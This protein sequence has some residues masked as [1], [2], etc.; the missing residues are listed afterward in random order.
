MNEIIAEKKNIFEPL[1]IPETFLE[2]A[3]I[4]IFDVGGRLIEIRQNVGEQFHLIRWKYDVN[5]NCIERR[6]WRDLQTAQSATGRVKTVKYFYDAQ[7][8]LTRKMD[9]DTITKYYYDCLNRLV[10]ERKE[11]LK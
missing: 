6:E 1:E 11:R 9:G 2:N 8:R 10:R 3:G 4:K 7:N 5:D